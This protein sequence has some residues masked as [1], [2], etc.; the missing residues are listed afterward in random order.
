MKNKRKIV[1]LII[2]FIITMLISLNVFATEITDLIGTVEYS[3]EYKNWLK[4]SDEEKKEVIQPRMFNIPKENVE[5][6][7]PLKNGRLLRSALSSKYSLQE[8]IPENIVVKNQQQTNSCWTFGS[9]ASL[10]TN[11]ALKNYYNGNSAKVYDLSE[12]HMEY[13]TSREFLNGEINTRGFNRK[14]DDGGNSYLYSAYLTNEM[15]AINEKDMPFESKNELISLNSIQDKEVTSQVYD[16]EWFPSYNQSD[17]LTQIKQQMKEYIKNYGAIE[18]G[19]HGSDLSNKDCYNNKTGAIYCDSNLKYKINHSVA[20]IGWDDNYSVNNFNEKLKP[21]NNGAWIIKN[22]WGTEI[23]TTFDELKIILFKNY[24]DK[25]IE[26]GWNEASDIPDSI[27]EEFLVEEGFNEENGYAIQDRKVI[28]KFGDKGMMYVSYEDANIYM[29]NK[30]TP[31]SFMLN[32]KKS[33][34]KFILD[35][36]LPVQNY[37]S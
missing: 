26:N 36:V 20:I 35:T 34:C 31:I 1:S 24:K 10:E 16:I 8:D 15:G 4:L 37:T 28:Q 30:K 13:A 21:K 29:Q 11:L 22:S 18:V 3:E 9:L 12:R 23:T 14:I 7:N 5:V 33:R 25:C 6:K 17:D 32:R 2:V 19:V 27:I